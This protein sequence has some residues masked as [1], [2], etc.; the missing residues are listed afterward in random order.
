MK[1]NRRTALKALAVGGATVVGAR[2]VVKAA[3]HHIEATDEKRVAMLYD[4][5]L[6]IGCKAC[7]V[8]CAEANG[9]APDTQESNGM[10]QMPRYL[11]DKT[12]NIIKLYNDP[13]TGLRS[14]VKAQCMHCIDPACVA[15]CPMAALQ[16]DDKGIVFW[17]GKTCI[18][19]RYCQ[20]ACPFNIPKFEWDKVNP[21]I[22]KCEFCRH[23][24]PE[25]KGPAC[26]EVCPRKAVIYGTRAELLKEA[27]KRIGDNPGRYYKDL[28]Y[29]EFEAGGTQVLYLTHLDPKLLGHLVPLSNESLPARVE[30]VQNTLYMGFLTPFVAYG[31]V[32][33]IMAKRWKAHE[34]EAEEFEKETGLKEQI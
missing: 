16:I 12:K 6:C 28:V 24:M 1:V 32:A 7:V 5:T 4:T 23:R 26:C 21:K 19:C 34:A 11:N 33:S 13:K 8:A 25:G 17:D 20:I 14:F 31:A 3:P 22:V 10:Y 15:G 30:S 18:G 29:G 9:L 2:A 27:K